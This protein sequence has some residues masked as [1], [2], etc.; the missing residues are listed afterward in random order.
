MAAI[1]L[2][3]S[4]VYG[5]TKKICQTIEAELKGRGHRVSV[6][7]LAEAAASLARHDVV[8]IGASVRHGRHRPALLE[9]IEANRELLAARPSAFFSVNLVARKPDKNTPA[10]NPYVRRLLAR[11][12]WQPRLVGVFAGNIDYPR[13]R[14]LDRNVI[15]FIMC[16]TGGPTDGKA[17]IEFTDWDEVRRYAGAISALAG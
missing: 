17:R 7:P 15:R 1:L 8:A 4:S 13:Y 11:T 5:Y 9:F 12:P 6:L 2:A 16:L 14:A 3:Y 10:T